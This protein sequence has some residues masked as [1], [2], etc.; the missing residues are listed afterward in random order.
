M[1]L[2]FG[3]AAQTSQNSPQIGNSAKFTITPVRVH[4]TFL[5]MEMVKRD[6]NKLFKKYNEYDAYR[7]IMFE[8]FASPIHMQEDSFEDKL[9]NVYNF[10]KPLFP[11]ITQ[12]PLINELT[13]V[14]NLP[15]V[16]SQDPYDVDTNQVEYYYFQPLNLWTTSHQNALPD[17]LLEWME[18]ESS[19]NKADSYSRA[20]GGATNNT[21]KTNDTSINLGNT[22]NE[23]SNIKILETY[24]G[25]IL[26]EGRW[27][28]SIRFGSTVLN[29]NPWSNTGTN[30]DPILILRNGQAPA[31][32]NAWIPTIEKINEDLGSIYFGSTQQIPLET[33]NISFKSYS[34]PPTTPSQYEGKQIMINSGRLVFNSNEDHLILSSVKSVNLNA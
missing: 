9:L 22:F 8:P 30:G 17:P 11:N 26:Y 31:E 2:N 21:T 3:L 27:G 18:Q 4:F 23:K 29:Q 10:A 34:T 6:Y 32:G 5:D 7:G 12:V 20:F 15:S 13:Y 24:E 14:I 33:P 19:S 25:D 16:R 1:A 28:Q